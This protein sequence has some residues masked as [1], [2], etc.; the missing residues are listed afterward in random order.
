MQRTRVT[1]RSFLKYSGGGLVAAG[2]AGAGAWQL[3]SRAGAQQDQEPLDPT[4]IPKFATELPIPR[5]FAPTVVRD[6]SGNVVRHDY[7]VAQR[8]VR[9]PVL[10]PGFPPTTVLAYGGRVAIPGSNRTENVFT[11]PGPVFDNTR[12]IPSRVTWRNRLDQPHFLPVDPNIHWANPNAIE[13]VEPPFT[14]FPPGYAEAQSPVPMVVHT[15][16]LVVKPQFDGTADEWFTALRHL[17]PSYVSN[18][19]DMPNEQPSTQLFYHDHVMGMTRLDIYAGLVGPAYFIRDPNSPLDQPDSPLPS[20]EFEIPLAIASRSFL[21]DGS[22]DFPRVGPSPFFPYMEAEDFSQTM[23][24]NGAVWP[25]LNV[26]R[27]QYRFRMLATANM[28]VFEFFFDLDGTTLPFAVIGADGGYLP[29]PLEVDRVTM[30]ITER[31]DALFDFSPFEPG[32]QIIMRNALISE[33]G[34]ESEGDDPV[35][36]GQIMRFTVVDSEPVPPP[37]LDP[38][39]FPPRA[40]LIPDAPTRTK[41]LVRFRDDE[42]HVTE[43]DRTRTLDGLAFTS[44]PTELPLIGSTEQ[45]ELVN[46]NEAEDDDPDFGNHQIHIHLLEFQIV[47]RQEFDVPRFLQDWF[48]FNG[49]QP[50]TRPIV[51]DMNNYLIG[52]PIPPEPNETGWKDTARSFPEHVTR[53]VVRWAPQ[54]VPT[55]GVEPGQNLFPIDVEFPSEIDPVTGPGYVWHCHMINHEDHEMMRQLAVVHAWAAGVAY[56]AGKVVTHENMNYRVRVDHTST[57]VEPPPARFDLWERVNNN[58]GSWQPQIIYAIE[59]RVL[60]EGQLF[61][62]LHVHQAEP[63]QFPPDHPDVW[64]ALPMTAKEQLVAFCDPND[65]ETAEFFEIGENGTEEEARE[66]LQAALAVCRH[67]HR[68]PSSGITEDAIEFTVPDGEEFRPEPTEGTAFY[69]TMSRLLDITVPALR[70]GQQ[71]RVNG[72]T[73]RTGR[74]YPLPPQRNMGYI[75]ETTGGATFIAR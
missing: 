25:N 8:A 3:T 38:G 35:G 16:G 67:V 73:M 22:L 34:D 54:E 71:V 26:Q 63:G 55:G 46:T 15:H 17:G 56:P 42:E 69:E 53:L 39:L 58:D 7:A 59:D 2:A 66:V 4:T 23:L 18:V 36:A 49:H 5:V 57:E 48:L 10:P 9:Q 51:L 72:R 19:Y 29:A 60:H 37:A 43:T 61:S 31:T 32:T 47:N 28:R 64:E 14:P 12:G 70:S 50:M 1:R 27:R 75:I 68:M 11:F 52:D 30:G 21:T 74:N 62:A 44:P 40:E 6:R 45:W 33:P 13:R 65:P 41:A 24:V 20:G